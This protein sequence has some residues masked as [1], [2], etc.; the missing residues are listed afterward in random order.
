MDGSPYVT[1]NGNHILDCRFPQGIA[2]ADS[3]ERAIAA[4]PGAVESGLFVGM[5][6]LALIGLDG[7]TVRRIDRP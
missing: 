4:V 7:G 1:D 2:D 5:A 3:L 6:H